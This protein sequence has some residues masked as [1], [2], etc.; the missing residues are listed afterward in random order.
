MVDL[1]LIPDKTRVAI[2]KREDGQVVKQLRLDPMSPNQQTNVARA[3]GVTV[4]A[5]I[6][7]CDQVRTSGQTVRVQLT[8]SAPDTGTFIVRDMD[9]TDEQGERHSVSPSEFLTSKLPSIPVDKLIAWAD[10]G[11]CC[12]LDI[13]Y[14]ES[15]PPEKLLLESIVLARLSPRPFA[16]HFSRGGGLHLFYIA[17]KGFTGEELASVAALRFRMIDPTA[18][19]ELKKGVRGPGQEITHVV[20][21]QD[22]TGLLLDWLREPNQVHSGP[23]EYLEE[24]D[25]QL[26][27]RYP[28]E[29]CPIAP[30]VDGGK[31]R[32][33]V[34]VRDGGIHC[35][36]CEAQGRVFGSRHPGFFPWAALTGHPTSGDVGHMVRNL[37]H[38]GHAK[39]VLQERYGLVGKLAEQAYSAALKAYHTGKTSFDLVPG[40][41]SKDIAKYARV[42]SGWMSIDELIP[43][44]KNVQAAIA[45][46]P[47]CQTINTKGEVK[48]IPVRVTN[49]MESIDL[50][51]NGYPPIQLIFGTKM[52]TEYLGGLD[53]T[54]VAVPHPEIRKRGGNTAL[55]KYVP[56]TKRMKIDKAK[57]SI[58]QIVPGVDWTLIELILCGVGC[59]QETELGLPPRI[60][61]TGPSGAAKTSH[62][63]IAAAIAG[64]RSGEPTVQ[65][66][67][68]RLR[69]A[70]MGAIQQGPIVVINEIFKDAYRNNRKQKPA[71]ALE[72]VLN[73]EKESLTHVLYKG[74]EK[75]GKQFVLGFTEIAL[76]LDIKDETQIARRIRYHRLDRSKRDWPRTIAAAGVTDIHL[77]R[78]VSTE[79]SDACNSILSD[80]VDRFFVQAMT[81]QEQAEILGVKTIEESGDFIDHTPFLKQ[82]FKLVCTAPEIV[83][84]H[85]SQH[86]PRYKQITRGDTDGSDD[87]EEL[88]ALYTMFADGPGAEWCASRRLM[89]KDWSSVLGVDDPVK[90][91]MAEN[92]SSVFVRFQVGPQKNPMKVNKEI[93]DPALLT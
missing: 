11:S 51:D 20:G 43:F 5:L 22:T 84:K 85:Y 19:V 49:M 14:H 61:V 86:Y 91:V 3:L 82:F 38:W 67:D 72:P 33:P 77:L 2:I 52:A 48:S 29:R 55:P 92:G 28:H 57:G 30:S 83:N 40:V 32:D 93:I 71:Q 21:D 41:F 70:I 65:G 54:V 31:H 15:K 46:F 73:L 47:S 26:G 80:V 17:A 69:Q 27:R 90:F 10:L 8:T 62:F 58:E 64:V 89:E 36:V 88:L 9:Q 68:E 81:F 24:N 7:W 37:C 59:A 35:Y 6:G 63:R 50:T 66:S 1:E 45:T 23:E 25:Y 13:D 79:V 56:F 75:L 76:P 74:P 53:R 78:L 87:S 16:W 34:I 60:F 42:G 18:G 4:T 39:W 12:C 44:S